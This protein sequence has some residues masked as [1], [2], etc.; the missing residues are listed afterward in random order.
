MKF[1]AEKTSPSAE[2][3][4]R[5]MLEIVQAFGESFGGDAANTHY[6]WFGEI[7]KPKFEV[8]RRSDKSLPKPQAKL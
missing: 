8:L 5:Q 2:I 3:D 6:L 4:E 1:F 7:A